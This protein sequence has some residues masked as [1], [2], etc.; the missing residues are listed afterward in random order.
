MIG[1]EDRQE[2]ARNIEAT[3]QAGARLHEACAVVGI[4][5]RTLQRWNAHGAS[6]RAMAGPQRYD[7][8]PRM[9]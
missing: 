1:L 5:A 6:N 4:S 3:R 8:R 2:H 7:R 9:H